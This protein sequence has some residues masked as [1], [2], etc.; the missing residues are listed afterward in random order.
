MKKFI[1]ILNVMMPMVLLAQFAPGPGQSG[2]TAMHADSSA[3]VAWATGCTVN[4]G[5]MN[6]TNPSA[7]LAGS[8]WP[9]ENVIGYPEG[10][11]GVT[12]L[13]DGGVATVTFASPICNRYDS[14]GHIV[15]DPWPTAFAS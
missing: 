14:Q 15:N 13:G 1:L 12:C 8:G 4:H 5:P 2:T 10:T 3:F 11:M 7:G 9:A 6:I